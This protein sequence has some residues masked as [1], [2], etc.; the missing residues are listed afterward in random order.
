MIWFAAALAVL[1][2]FVL[3][4]LRKRATRKHV[5]NLLRQAAYLIPR[6]F[7]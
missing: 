6:Y 7:V 5:W 3:L 4:P 1:I 2:F